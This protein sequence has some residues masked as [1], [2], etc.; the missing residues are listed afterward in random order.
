MWVERVIPYSPD[1][2]WVFARSIKGSRISSVR[3]AVRK[4]SWFVHH[5]DPFS[6]PQ[7]LPRLIGAQR[8]LQL[9]INCLRV[10]GEHWD[11][12]AGNGYRQIGFVHDFS[13]LADHLPF[14]VRVSRFLKPP[15]CTSQNIEGDLEWV[16]FELA[17]VL[18]VQNSVSLHLKFFNG[19]AASAG[20]GLICAGNYP[21]HPCSIVEWL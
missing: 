20:N 17:G 2:N 6:I 10:T 1:I 7:N 15:V 3:S 18:T 21:F 11:A 19:C 12:N 16:N 13:G 4:L 14:L 5:Y 8:S 9:N